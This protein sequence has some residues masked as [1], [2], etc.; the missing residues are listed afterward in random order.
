MRKAL[1]KAKVERLKREYSGF[2]ILNERV[3]PFV[4][5]VRQSRVPPHFYQPCKAGK[6]PKQAIMLEYAAPNYNRSPVRKPWYSLCTS[7][8]GF[9]SSNF[10]GVKSKILRK[11]L[12]MESLKTPFP[13]PWPIYNYI[14]NYLFKQ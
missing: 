4:N 13:L 12:F 1:M 5:E 8:S 11:V 9:R 7:G 10:W 3:F 14:R 6:C 2:Q